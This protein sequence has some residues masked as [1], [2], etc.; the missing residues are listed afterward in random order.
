MEAVARDFFD[1]EVTMEV[2]NQLEE[3]E[4]TGKK[5]H[6]VFLVKQFNQVHKTIDLFNPRGVGV[7]L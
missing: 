2:L 1:S 3:D 6:V 4:R 7:R 5:E